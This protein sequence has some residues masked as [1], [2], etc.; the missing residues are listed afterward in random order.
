MDATLAELEEYKPPPS[1]THSET[2]DD[3]DRNKYELMIVMRTHIKLS[4]SV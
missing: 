1:P 3:I 4:N 2:T